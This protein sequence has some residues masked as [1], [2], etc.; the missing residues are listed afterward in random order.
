M[1]N[2]KPFNSELLSFSKSIPNFQ[3]QRDTP[4]AFLE[5]C[6][7][8]IEEREPAVKAFSSINLKGARAAADAASLRYKRG[9]CLSLIDGMVVAIKDVF[10]TKDM[11]T[12]FNSEL[13]RG[14]QTRW[15]GA[16]PYFFRSGGAVI[17][18]KTVTT[19]FAFGTPGP[20]RNAWDISRTPGGSSSGSGAAV[21][22]SMV[23]VAIG[24][25]VRGSVLRPAAFNGTYAIKPS[26]GSFNL[27]GGF[28]SALSMSCIGIITGTLS[29]M[30]MTAWWLSQQ[31]GE[32]GYPSISGSIKL[33]KAFKPRKLIR[34]E[35]PGWAET[36]SIT[37]NEF[38]ETCEM[39]AVSGVEIISRR[40]NAD[41]ER[42]EKKLAVLREVIDLM[43][44]YEARWPLMMFNE[45]NSEKLGERV[46][47]RAKAAAG[48]DPKK[49]ASC[50]EWTGK[51][52]KF[53]NSFQGTA[54]GFIT[55]NQTGPAPEGLAVGNTVY[56]EPSSLLGVPALNLPFLSVQN[57]PLG[58]QLLGFYRKDEALTAVGRWLEERFHS[59]KK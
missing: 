14:N 33:P 22:A 18:G 50:L 32:P 44:T 38:E 40:E 56:G 49:Y 35:T 54:D 34:L 53:W 26:K 2:Y 25:Q 28:P 31:G 43:L 41:V 55:L 47:T 51:I 6:I 48:L 8:N 46:R 59:F 58:L 11:P 9:R 37:K 29:D 12:T 4:R 30:W 1:V 45:N 13:F 15:D 27:L 5:R 36:D 39:L 19:E 16:C 24:T 17:I 7:E 3:N 57:M 42:L 23:P 20:T 21:G 52:R 10:D